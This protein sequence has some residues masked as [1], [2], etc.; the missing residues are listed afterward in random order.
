M[1]YACTYQV[2]GWTCSAAEGNDGP[3][4]CSLP[5]MAVICT[6]HLGEHSDKNIACRR[7]YALS[8][9]LR[10]RTLRDQF[11]MA[12]LGLMAHNASPGQWAFQAEQAYAMADA[13]MAARE[14]K[15]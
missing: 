12:A 15:T 7:T 9:A 14:R 8:A 2:E 6:C 5:P 1:A 3:H 13:M 10:K 11:A 4:L